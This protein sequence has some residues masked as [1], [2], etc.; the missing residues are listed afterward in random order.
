MLPDNF[1]YKEAT[2]DDLSLILKWTKRLMSHEALDQ[3]IELQLKKNISTLLKEW[4]KNL[5]S[6][7]NSLIIIA[8][9]ESKTPLSSAALIIGYIQLQPNDFTQYTFHG[10]IQMIWVEEEYRNKG[11]A[12]QLV[13]YI[14]DAFR[15]LDIPYC[16]LQYSDTNLEAETF[17]LKSGYHKVSH[18]CRKML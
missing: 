18:H 17:W 15:H 3:D 14:E 4:L 7:K 10:V 16:E 5:I 12:S 13:D 8:N 9:D 2:I 11:L 6:D 1:S